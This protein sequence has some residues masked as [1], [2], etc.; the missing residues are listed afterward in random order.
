MMVLLIEFL[1]LNR[2]VFILQTEGQF[3]SKIN[4]WQAFDA[5]FVLH[6]K[7]R[8]SQRSQVIMWDRLSSLFVIIPG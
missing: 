5:P 3:Y 6:T 4:P 2:L 8:K 7:D 1:R